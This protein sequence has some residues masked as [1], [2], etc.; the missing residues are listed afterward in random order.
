MALGSA[1]IVDLILPNTSP[2]VQAYAVGSSTYDIS[3]E[4]V[5]DLAGNVSEWTSTLLLW[6]KDRFDLAGIWQPG[7][8][9]ILATR[10]GSFKQRLWQVSSVVAVETNESDAALGFRC[11][12][13]LSP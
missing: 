12:Q 4:G 8:P 10:G 11:A 9:A 6:N 7:C 5:S 3:V 1:T 13:D 2:P